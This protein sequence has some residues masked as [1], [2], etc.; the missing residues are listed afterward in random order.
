MQ[1]R[2]MR[3]IAGAMTG[4][5]LMAS[6]EL[7]GAVAMPE[8]AK[9]A[10]VES[11]QE[12][13]PATIADAIDLKS[14][15]AT[16]AVTVNPES[17]AAALDSASDSEKQAANTNAAQSDSAADAVTPSNADAITLLG[18]DSACDYAFTPATN[19]V[20]AGYLF[21]AGALQIHHSELYQ[22]GRL[23]AYRT[24]G[25]KL[26][27]VRLSAGTEYVL[28]IYGTGS[29]RIEIARDALSRCYDQ[30]LEMDEGGGNATSRY[31]TT[32]NLYYHTTYP[33]KAGDASTRAGKWPKGTV[34]DVV[35]GWESAG[36]GYTW[37]KVMYSGGSYY[38]AKEYLERV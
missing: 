30:P 27:S 5:M 20:F 38:A 25:T 36:G 32:A 22:D 13:Q 28:K 8:S 11:V 3:L 34:V 33:A 21:S 35:D 16:I 7:S 6:G 29:G 24:G 4:W 1:K 18:D 10:N 2:I 37:V 19:G 15:A 26:F 9:W 31:R 12:N 23:I 14:A 17:A